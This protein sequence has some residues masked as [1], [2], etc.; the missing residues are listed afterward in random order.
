[1]H[2]LVSPAEHDPRQPIKLAELDGRRRVTGDKPDDAA[3]DFGRR[4]EVVLAH[5]HRKVDLRVELDV[6]REA[7]PELCTGPCNEPHRELALEH[8]D[9]DAEERAVREEAE[10]EGRGYL[11]GRIRDADIEVWERRLHEVANNDLK[12]SLLRPGDT[13]R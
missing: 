3:L 9:C 10:D 8:Q 7:R 6:R 4:A 5:M 11:V 2:R 13:L 12:F 1:M